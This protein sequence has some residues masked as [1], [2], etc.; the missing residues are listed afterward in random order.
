MLKSFQKFLNMVNVF[1]E[2]RYIANI[3]LFLHLCEFFFAKRKR[4]IEIGLNVWYYWKWMNDNLKPKT[5]YQIIITPNH[6]S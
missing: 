4:K 1:F 2:K 6:F 5:T 3:Y